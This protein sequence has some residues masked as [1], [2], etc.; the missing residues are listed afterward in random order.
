MQR[1]AHGAAVAGQERQRVLHDEGRAD[2]VEREDARQHLGIEVTKRVL[3]PDA[4]AVG[5]A[6]G[7]DDELHVTAALGDAAADH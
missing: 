3:R 1:Y 2:R 7:V 5:E 6:G 4:V